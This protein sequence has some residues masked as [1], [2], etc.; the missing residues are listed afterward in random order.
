[1]IACLVDFNGELPTSV[2]L[3]AN[4]CDDATNN[5]KIIN[6]QPIDGV[7]QKFGVCTKQLVLEDREYGAKIIEWVHMLRILG[8]HKVHMQIRNVHPDIVEVLNHLQE[9]ELIEWNH[10]KD[11][12]GI[13]DTKLYSGQHRLLQMNV[14][15]DCFY[16]VKDL[17][18]FVVILDP[19]EVIMPVIKEDKS[20]QDIFNHL[21]P[22]F[23][24]SDSISNANVY[25]PHQKSEIVKY[26]PKHHYMLQ[27]VQRSIAFTSN[28]DAI[29][30]F[31]R[32]GLV[33]V[34]H[35][36]YAIKCLS[37]NDSS[38]TG[39]SKTVISK[40]I[41]QLSHYRNDV[42]DEF[43]ATVLD[44]KI[45]KFKN[46]LIKAVRETMNQMK[47]EHDEIFQ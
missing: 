23:F 21:D 11:P 40:N 3:T 25:Y 36:H 38:P 22:V 8:A 44:T 26:I 10:Y 1:L 20:W 31:V 34:V 17:Y 37:Y 29:K 27:H 41:S 13:A 32:P 14:M 28:I 19:D 43:K 16:K 7:K 47:E 35:N 30:S 5:L 9:K 2:S 6:N 18:E 33:L 24:H 42:D 45:W 46:E 4:P 12:K 15:N 39:C